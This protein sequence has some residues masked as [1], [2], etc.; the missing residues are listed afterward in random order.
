MSAILSAS[1]RFISIFYILSS[2]VLIPMRNPVVSS[3]ASYWM[4]NNS[5]IITLT[6]INTAI[7]TGS[8]IVSREL[9]S[10]TVTK[11]EGYGFFVR[12]NAGIA[13]INKHSLLN[14]LMTFFASL[15][16]GPI[17]FIK[18]R[19]DRFIFFALFGSFNSI[20][21][22]LLL[23]QITGGVFVFSTARLLFDFVYNITFKFTMFEWFRK[24]IVSTKS[25]KVFKLFFIRGKQDILTT[26]FKNTIL[27]I[28]RFRG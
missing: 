23:I 27:N 9:L 10:N 12:D 22:Q 24:P 2:I 4:A 18:R 28:F 16:A 13:N 6:F 3:W 11:D 25:S 19:S 15:L 26:L 1:K 20:M 17:F 7:T 14:I 21:A 8:E 5:K